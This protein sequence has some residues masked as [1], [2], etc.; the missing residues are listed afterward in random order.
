MPAKLSGDNLIEIPG[1]VNE[2]KVRIERIKLAFFSI[3][4]LNLSSFGIIKNWMR[5]LSA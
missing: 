1:R 4:L 5:G 3:V 2:M